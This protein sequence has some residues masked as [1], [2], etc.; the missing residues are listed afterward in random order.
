MPSYR[1]LQFEEE[2]MLRNMYET[3][4]TQAEFDYQGY[5][6]P[7]K[8]PQ[9]LINFILKETPDVILM[10]VIMREM[11]GFRATEIIKADERT[12]SIP[13]CFLT[14]L[15]SAKDVA[16]GIALGAVKYLVSGNTTPNKVVAEVCKILDIPVPVF[17]KLQPTLKK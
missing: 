1:I 14:N 11:D 6:H 17:E 3:K 10:S 8:D 15:S 2:E 9:D 5:N 16:R 4:L 12:R 7:P 13:I